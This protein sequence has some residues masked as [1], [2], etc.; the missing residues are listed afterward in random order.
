M[1]LG[2]TSDT[3]DHLTARMGRRA[4]ERMSAI[5]GRAAV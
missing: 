4:S 1:R 2:T 5:L 3:Y